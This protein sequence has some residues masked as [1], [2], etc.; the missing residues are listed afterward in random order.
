MIRLDLWLTL[1]TG[2]KLRAAELAFGDA[3]FQG[4]YASAFRYTPDYLA[5]TRAFA[6]DPAALPLSEQEFHG[7]QLDTPL[8]AL[9]DALPDDWGRRL[10]ILR[11]G[12]LRGRQSEPHLLQALAGQGLGALGFY[13]PSQSPGGEANAAA[14]LELKALLNA[15]QRLERE[16]GTPVI[17]DTTR[18]LLA[19]GSSPGGARPKAL[20]H[21][22]ENQW[23][24]KF[25]SRRDD[26]DMVGLEAAS[27]EL[28]R[29][30]GLD[31]PDFR[32]VEL[33]D[34][35]RVLLVK[36]FDL[37][38]Q[39]GRLHML[40]FRAL[41]QASG[42]YVLR[43]VDLIAALRQH[44]AQPEEDVPRLY[45]QMVF[46]ALLGNT[47]DHLKNFWLL[48]DGNGYR[49]SPA[50]DLLP[51]TGARRE[52]VLLFDLTPLPPAPAELASLGRK[53]GITGTA[54]ICQEVEAAVTRF[55]EIAADKNV[56]EI[57]INH[58]EQDIARR[59]RSRA[60]PLSPSPSPACGGGEQPASPPRR[61]R[62]G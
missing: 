10:L 36:R 17:D 21:D 53:W 47:D 6:L 22:A 4:R 62:Q 34:S 39:G 44:S 55:A 43:Y 31:V 8:L 28:A 12:L 56:P 41:L 15:A 38:P 18:S 16:V 50:F 60:A 37:T 33:S 49:L 32:L 5:D 20:V 14:L 30:A 29:L 23:I 7:K 61:P 1:A 3:D 42:Y 25:P 27:L 13:P 2:E 11:H 57:E 40:S 35:R 24:A 48:A 52:H 26:V 45:R 54:S 46:N 9:E 59:C 19:A 51:D 58:F